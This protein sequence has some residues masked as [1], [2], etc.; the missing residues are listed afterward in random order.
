LEGERQA[1]IHAGNGRARYGIDPV[2]F[3]ATG[4]EI[5]FWHSRLY[6]PRKVSGFFTTVAIGD[7]HY[8][9]CAGNT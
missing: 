2:I 3:L 4:N 8:G 6:P 7:I 5:W 1:S 9:L